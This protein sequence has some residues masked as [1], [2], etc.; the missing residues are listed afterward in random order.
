M[1]WICHQDAHLSRGRWFIGGR[2]TGKGAAAAVNF[3]RPRT[4]HP[5][6]VGGYS[7]EEKVDVLAR[8]LGGE[9][10]GGKVDDIS[11]A[12]EGNV[13]NCRRQAAA[14]ENQR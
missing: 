2:V 8:Q 7:I 12:A 6:L 5:S 3:P 14:L 9:A 10:A 4:G 11:A 1:V 13:G